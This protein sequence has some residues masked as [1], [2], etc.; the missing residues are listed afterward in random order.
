MLSRQPSFFFV[1]A[2]DLGSGELERFPNRYLAVLILIRS[3]A[4][5]SFEKVFVEHRIVAFL[6]A[7]GGG[8]DHAVLAGKLLNSTAAGVGAVDDD[9][10]TDVKRR[11]H[12]V[13]FGGGEIGE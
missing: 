1:K 3:R 8:D 11:Q 6:A 9:G 5:Q 10:A 7:A 2:L 13:V 12:L 4:F